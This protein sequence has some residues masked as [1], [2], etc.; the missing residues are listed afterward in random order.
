MY[1]IGWRFNVS[2]YQIM[3]ANPTVNPRA[4][5]VGT[6]LLIPITPNPNPTETPMVALTP[7]ATPLFSARYPAPDCYPDALGGLWC[8][9]LVTND[10]ANPW[11]THRRGDPAL[12]RGNPARVCHHAPQPAPSRRCPPADRLFPAAD[13]GGFHRHRPGGFPAAGHAR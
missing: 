10:R 4:M 13:P 12:W 2:P 8:F 9:V 11:K 3:T 6:T 1:S 5:G 7:T